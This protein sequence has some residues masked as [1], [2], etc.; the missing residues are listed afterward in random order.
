M[1]NHIE[2]KKFRKMNKKQKQKIKDKERWGG[3]S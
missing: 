1:N 2:Q 3:V